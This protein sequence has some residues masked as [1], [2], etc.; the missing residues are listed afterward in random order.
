MKRFTKY[1]SN[2]IAAATKTPKQQDYIWIKKLKNDPD[3]QRDG[4]YCSFDK[5][6]GR[7]HVVF[8]RKVNGKNDGLIAHITVDPTLDDIVTKQNKRWEC[9]LDVLIPDNYFDHYDEVADA[10]LDFFFN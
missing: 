6:T 4:I 10:I 3:F 2:S 9:S 7:A 8:P 1:P 5:V